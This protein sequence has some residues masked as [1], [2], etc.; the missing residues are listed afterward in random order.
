VLLLVVPLVIANPISTNIEEAKSGV[1][2]PS[3]CWQCFDP[4]FCSW[5]GFI[6][7]CNGILS[8]GQ[9]V[10]ASTGLVIGSLNSTSI[11]PNGTILLKD[12]ITPD[13]QPQ[14]MGGL[15]DSEHSELVE[16]RTVAGD[17]DQEDS[18]SSAPRKQLER[19]HDYVLNCGDNNGPRYRRCSSYPYTYSCQ[20]TGALDNK[21][22]D[23]LY[24]DEWCECQKIY[25]KYCPLGNSPLVNCIGIS[26]SELPDPTNTTGYNQTT[27]L[28]NGTSPSDNGNE[29]TPN[30]EVSEVLQSEVEIVAPG[31]ATEVA[32]LKKRHGYALDCASRIGSLQK[33]CSNLGYFC[34]STGVVKALHE[35][36]I[37]CSLFCKCRIFPK[38]EISE[39]LQ[40]EVDLVAPEPTAE[41]AALAKRHNYALD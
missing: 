15:P 41:P 12:P 1:Q 29:T 38:R 3:F 17:R 13:L 28:P 31:P 6:V 25:I 14:A 30:R 21:G 8:S 20:R 36:R 24:C 2:D 7:P 39:A 22:N 10:E 9:I 18:E 27:P 40:Q 33:D 34:T 16:V 19:R 32:A 11:L 37:T 26:T 5:K 23:S 4:R 35:G